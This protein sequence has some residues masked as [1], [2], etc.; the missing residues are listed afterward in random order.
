VPLW[1]SICIFSKKKKKGFITAL[2]DSEH[3]D[4]YFMKDWSGFTTLYC[5][6]WSMDCFSEDSYFGPHSSVAHDEDMRQVSVVWSQWEHMAH[7]L[8]CAI[9]WM[10]EMLWVVMAFT[11]ISSFL[12]MIAIWVWTPPFIFT[13]YTP[14]PLSYCLPR[15]ENY[16]KFL[17]KVSKSS[18][19]SSLFF[20]IS[21]PPQAEFTRLL[22]ESFKPS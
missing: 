18:M 7:T 20:S 12:S 19:A 10:G 1:L 15:D 2:V 9:C 6:C 8:I 5:K 4:C 3:S 17:F 16:W 14:F 21:T 13:S 22:L 11:S